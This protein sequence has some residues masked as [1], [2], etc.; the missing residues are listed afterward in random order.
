[1]LAE[2]RAHGSLAAQRLV[3]RGSLARPDH[4][5]DD[6]TVVVVEIV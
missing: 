3:A 4:S 2:V 5:G 1:M 6:L